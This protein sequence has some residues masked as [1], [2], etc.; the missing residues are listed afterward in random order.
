MELQG[1]EGR[2]LVELVEGG[3]ALIEG[4]GGACESSGT[5]PERSRVQGMVQ[6]E[7]GPERDL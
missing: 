5:W 7:V 4:G 1:L 3:G 2:G 6:V